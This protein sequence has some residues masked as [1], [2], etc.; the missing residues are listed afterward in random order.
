MEMQAGNYR[1]VIALLLPLRKAKL[2][3]SEEHNVLWHDQGRL[4]DLGSRRMLVLDQ[5]LEGSQ[6]D[7][8]S[9]GQSWACSRTHSM[10]S[11]WWRWVSWRVSRG[12]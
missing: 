10:G 9:S 3:P 12:G 1:G 8:G 6:G 7:C 5:E 2:S 11:R 4:A